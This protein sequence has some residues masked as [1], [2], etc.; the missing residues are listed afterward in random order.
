MARQRI[1]KQPAF[2]ISRRSF[3]E[4]SLLIDI[5]TRDY[6]R[7]T[8]LAKGARRLKSPYR[9]V[10]HSFT[11]LLLSWSGKSSL[12][13]LTSADC[14]QKPYTFSHD[15]LMCAWYANELLQLFLQ[16]HDPH[17]EVFNHYLQLL[18]KIDHGY[19]IQ[20]S[21]RIFE[22]TLLA[23]VGYGLVLDRDSSNTNLIEPQAIY[24]YIPEIGLIKQGQT[25]TSGI[26]IS[27]NALLSFNNGKCP[28]EKEQLEIKYLTRFVI[29]WHTEGKEIQSRRIFKEIQ[30]Y[31]PTKHD[32]N[33]INVE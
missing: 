6:G 15:S 12:M 21:L 32:N 9:G 26:Q 24:H 16:R 20:W 22:K 25:V 28:N 30:H 13:T 3:S 5:F 18:E 33:L 4:S 10:L 8:L 7:I 27:G 1:S 11:V 17:E 23:E 29:N 14:I 19:Q 2:I 31:L